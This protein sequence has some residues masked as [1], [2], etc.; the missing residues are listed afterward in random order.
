MSKAE[1]T[2]F[3]LVAEACQADVAQ[4]CKNDESAA[5]VERLLEQPPPH[6]FMANQDPPLLRIVSFPSFRPM[7]EEFDELLNYFLRLSGA[8]PPPPPRFAR[9]MTDE[10][11]RRPPCPFAVDNLMQHLSSTTHPD[12]FHVVSEKLNE[13]GREM[14]TTSNQHEEEPADA[15]DNVIATARRLQEVT[16]ATLHSFRRSFLPFAEADCLEKSYQANKVSQPCAQTLDSLHAIRTQQQEDLQQA[17]QEE[18]DMYAN[19]IVLYAFIFLTILIVYVKTHKKIKSQM[20]L[21]ERIL[22]TLYS[23]PALKKAM[24]AAVGSIGHVPPTPLWRSPKKQAALKAARYFR[25]VVLGIMTVLWI[26]AP[27]KVLPFACGVAGFFFWIVLFGTLRKDKVEVCTCCCCGTT[28]TEAAQGLGNSCCSCC[29]GTGVCCLECA[30]CCNPS[31]GDDGCACCGG[32]GCCCCCGC[33]CCYKSEACCSADG[34]EMK[35]ACCE[36]CSCCCC[37]DCGCNSKNSTKRSTVLTV[38]E[39]NKLA[40]IPAYEGVPIQIV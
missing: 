34:N 28:T 30:D 17:R 21:R 22:V 14:M 35:A 23:K 26:W 29:S 2:A 15:N 31:G 10:P 40:G 3:A 36:G 39:D 6:P 32:A 13:K 8:P 25:V 16:P 1:Q 18:S 33:S 9:L 7:E 11:P 20:R 4:L 38:S 24:E 27:E 37:C 19:L 12:H 5:S